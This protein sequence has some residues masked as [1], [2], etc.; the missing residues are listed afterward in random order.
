MS[1]T[2]ASRKE[3]GHDI[4]RNRP[5]DSSGIQIGKDRGREG[6]IQRRGY[7]E[8]QGGATK[9]IRKELRTRT[10]GTGANA[11]GDSIIGGVWIECR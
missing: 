7:A 11:T 6:G 2:I 10:S 5:Q 1:R 9:G 4:K 8:C 3:L